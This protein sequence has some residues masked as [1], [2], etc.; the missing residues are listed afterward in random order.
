MGNE[1]EPLNPASRCRVASR[2]TPARRKLTRA[3]VF[4]SA[5]LSWVAAVECL[6]GYIIA[7]QA[8]PAAAADA[9][10]RAGWALAI[11]FSI[12]IV[13]WLASRRTRRNVQTQRD[14]AVEY[15][16]AA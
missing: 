15:R 13:D 16:K 7:R 6:H 3:V 2:G 1:S 11:C 5:G 4:V 10:T 8:N 12:L 14:G 9:L